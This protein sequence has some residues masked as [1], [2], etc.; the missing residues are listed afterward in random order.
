MIPLPFSLLPFDEDHHYR[1]KDPDPTSQSPVLSNWQ[2]LLRLFNYGESSPTT[3]HRLRLT[4]L[5]LIPIR[6]RNL[7]A[8][9]R[10]SDVFRILASRVS[11]RQ[12]GRSSV[13]VHNTQLSIV[14]PYQQIPVLRPTQVKDGHWV[15]FTDVPT[16]QW[17][18]AFTGPGSLPPDVPYNI[19]F[20]CSQPGYEAV[21]MPS[22]LALREIPRNNNVLFAAHVMTCYAL[23]QSFVTLMCETWDHDDAYECTDDEIPLKKYVDSYADFAQNQRLN[24]MNDDIDKTRVLHNTES[25]ALT[26]A[27][28]RYF[29]D[30]ARKD[31]SFENEDLVNCIAAVLSHRQAQFASGSDD[32]T[33]EP[34]VSATET[35]VSNEAQLLEGWYACWGTEGTRWL[36]IV[37]TITLGR[38]SC[39]VQA[40]PE[41][42][43]C[44]L[45][46]PN[47]YVE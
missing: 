21:Q 7:L 38:N 12:K 41:S 8:L 1:F 15:T 29:A 16:R 6:N 4:P 10:T 14:E 23:W 35:H 27:C 31:M 18:D 19:N 9:V 25:F 28:V 36:L 3:D 22:L 32:A 20:V 39:G 26:A 2:R 43:D 5:A 42:F 34:P 13:L 45:K 37:L 11:R 17:G 44:L 40:L 47:C 33:W 46:S 24:L 30:P